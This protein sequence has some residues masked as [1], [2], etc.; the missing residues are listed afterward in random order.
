MS[1]LPVSVGL[2]ALVRSTQGFSLLDCRRLSSRALAHCSR[3]I[4]LHTSLVVELPCP[5]QTAVLL[6]LAPVDAGTLAL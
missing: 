2:L 1:D 5:H 4:H 6:T 3:S